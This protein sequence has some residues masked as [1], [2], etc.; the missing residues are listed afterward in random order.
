MIALYGSEYS[1]RCRKQQHSDAYE[2]PLRT[3]P[4]SRS[5]STRYPSLFSSFRQY[6]AMGAHQVD[7]IR[8][9]S[10]RPARPALRS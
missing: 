4:E 10:S 1:R 7:T 5:L 3:E 6:L 2:V 8:S 9:K